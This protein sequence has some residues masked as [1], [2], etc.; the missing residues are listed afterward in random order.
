MKLK[1]PRGLLPID[2][3]QADLSTPETMY[4]LQASPSVN[5]SLSSQSSGLR[6]LQTP[7]KAPIRAPK[8]PKLDLNTQIE[9]D[10][11]K[12]GVKDFIKNKKR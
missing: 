10:I 4:Q 11:D 6:E 12:V 7:L 3:K 9:D 8:M 5:Q 2:K 1:Q